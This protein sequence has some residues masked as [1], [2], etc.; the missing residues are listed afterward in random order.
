M[1][2]VF[3]EEPSIDSQDLFLRLD[4][5]KEKMTSKKEQKARLAAATKS[6]EPAKEE[7]DPVTEGEGSEST[8]TAVDTVKPELDD[9]AP[10]KLIP[11]QTL[12]EVETEIDHFTVLLT[13]IEELFAPM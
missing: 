5:L 8:E 12:E 6:D 3:D 4:E 1:E 7:E 13:Y 9:D 10:V 11:P 2:T